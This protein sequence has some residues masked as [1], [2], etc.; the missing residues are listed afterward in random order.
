MFGDY[1]FL[2]EYELVKGLSLA[3][4]KGEAKADVK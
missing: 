3:G 2:L 4:V 1:A